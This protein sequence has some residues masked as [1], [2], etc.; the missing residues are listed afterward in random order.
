MGESP[1]FYLQSD[2]DL[3]EL[4]HDSFPTML[5]PDDVGAGV[6]DQTEQPVKLAGS[7]RDP[8]VE[9]VIATGRAQTE[10]DNP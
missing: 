5:D 9:R 7:I 1:R 4:D 2:L 3:T 6:G 8:R 10:S